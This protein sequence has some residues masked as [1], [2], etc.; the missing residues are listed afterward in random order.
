M[1]LFMG[2]FIDELIERAKRA[3]V[4]KRNKKSLEVKILAAILYFFGL[5][6]RKTSLYLSLFEEVSHESVRKYYHK[7]KYI[8]K[9]PK[10]KERKFIAVD[11]TIIKVGDRRVYVWAAIDVETKECLAIWVSMTR[12]Q[13][14]V[15]EFIKMVLKYCKNKPTFIVDRGSW[16]KSAF[17]RLGLSYEN[18]TFGRRNAVEQFFSILKSR[19]E[20]FFNRFPKN[21][22]KFRSTL[23][24][25]R[26]FALLYNLI[27]CYYKNDTS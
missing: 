19:T 26:S 18:E 15:S 7:I 24:W 10:K 25:L 11:E 3:K 9:E 23:S 4:F 16:Y 27:N 5:S 12:H 1:I 22:I 2:G 13:F 6:L 14:A 21:K 20:R 17:R 8:L